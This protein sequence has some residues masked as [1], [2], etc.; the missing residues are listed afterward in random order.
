MFA[1]GRSQKPTGISCRSDQV[2]ACHSGEKT[3]NGQNAARF[4]SVGAYARIAI[5]G[6][7]AGDAAQPTS[8]SA[9][10]GPSISTWSGPKSSRAAS[11]ERAEP[12][13]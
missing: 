6:R 9:S 3:A 12:G 8:G 4:G 1:A 7:M 5:G 2:S 13:P 11:S 10:A